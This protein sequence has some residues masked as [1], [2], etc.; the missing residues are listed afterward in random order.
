[1]VKYRQYEIYHLNHLR[2]HTSGMLAYFHTVYNDH[3]QSTLQ[4]SFSLPNKLHPVNRDHPRTLSTTI[5]CLSLW[6]ALLFMY[7]NSGIL[8]STVLLTL[9]LFILVPNFKI[10]L[11]WW[12]HLL[13]AHQHYFQTQRNTFKDQR[14]LWLKQ[15]RRT[16]HWFPG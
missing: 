4:N 5:L 16:P 14:L 10:K 8:C 6:I 1:M 9:A 2:V 13:P 12:A 15:Y 3:Q 7:S 11:G